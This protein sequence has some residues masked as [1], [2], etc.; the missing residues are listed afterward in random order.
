MNELSNLATQTL[1]AEL[2]QRALDAEFDDLYDERGTF[3]RKRIKSREYWYYQRDEDGDRKFTYVGPV[4][5]SAINDRVKKFEVI[6]VSFRQRRE[7]VRAL[8]AAGLPS[9]DAMSGALIEGLWRAGFFRLRGVLVGTLAFQCYSGILGTRLS[10][11]SLRTSDADL[12]QFY[13]VSRLVRDSMPPIL[14]VLRAVDGTFEPVPSVTRPYRAA[15]FRTNAGY[16]VEFL[17]PN[18]GSE[19][20]Q[21][22][23]TV[24][25]A[26]GGAAATPLRYLDFLIHDP[27]RSVV[28][29]KGGL[30][31]WVPSP[32][33]Y[34]IHKLIVAVVRREDPAKVAKDISQAEQLIRICLPQRSYSLFEAWV[35]A[36]ERGPSWRTNL[37]RGREML[38]KQ[39][40]DQFIFTLETHGWTESK[41]RTQRPPRIAKKAHT[42]AKKGKTAKR[43]ATA[44]RK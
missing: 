31:V 33:R 10:S 40:R 2:T 14:D 34:A 39:L 16:L 4:A 35:E 21:G 20:N 12:A 22:K 24:M 13:D 43:P 6:K 29:Y 7:I 32:E 9:P 41:W 5:D 30:P 11:V 38:P 17:T 18:R 27:V 36:S 37:K 25:P 15:R 19:A 1:F 44:R 23:P 42:P 8:I 3:T 26:L 28:L